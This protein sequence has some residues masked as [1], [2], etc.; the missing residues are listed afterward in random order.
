LLDFVAGLVVQQRNYLD[1]YIYDKWNGNLL[2]E[3]QVGEKFHPDVCQ[4]KDGQT[5]QPSLLTEADLVSLMDKNGIGARSF[6][7]LL[8]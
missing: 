7:L 8:V 1:V 5:S 2:P 4:L 3:F 6:S